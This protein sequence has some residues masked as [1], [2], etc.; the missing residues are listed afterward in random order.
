MEK[1]RKTKNPLHSAVGVV[2]NTVQSQI[3]HIANPLQVNRPPPRPPLDSFDALAQMLPPTLKTEGSSQ[4]KD[5]IKAIHYSRNL[6]K[7]DE[8]IAQRRR[9]GKG[10]VLTIDTN[11]PAQPYEQAEFTHDLNQYSHLN[12]GDETLLNDRSMAELSPYVD[13]FDRYPPGFGETL[14][15]KALLL[16]NNPLVPQRIRKLQTE[17]GTRKRAK[18]VSNVEPDIRPHHTKLTAA[19][20]D[21]PTFSETVRKVNVKVKKELNQPAGKPP[22]YSQKVRL[23]GRYLSELYNIPKGRGFKGSDIS[24]MV[25]DLERSDGN[26]AR[27]EINDIYRLRHKDDIARQVKNIVSAHPG[28]DSIFRV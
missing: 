8:T 9:K 12:S 18:S 26:V 20:V 16:D 17:Y 2:N 1:L 6:K 28:I 22:L 21:N 3:A 13:R 10:S 25:K 4:F 15:R 7:Y 24:N 19:D 11:L 27:D 14:R 5:A 23:Y